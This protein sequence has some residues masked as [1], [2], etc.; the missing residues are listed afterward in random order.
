MVCT[1]SIRKYNNDFY[2][3]CTSAH[4]KYR[5]ININVFVTVN[6]LV[7]SLCYFFIKSIYTPYYFNEPCRLQYFSMIFK[8]AHHGAFKLNEHEHRR[9]INAFYY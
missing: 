5:S 2:R 3:L 9:R 8:L 6:L 1:Y 7:Q 4:D